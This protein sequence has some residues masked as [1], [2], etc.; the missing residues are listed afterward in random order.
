MDNKTLR[1]KAQDLRESLQLVSSVVPLNPTQVAHSGVH[2]LVTDGKLKLT[3]TDG[4]TT[5]TKILTTEGDVDVNIVV[6]PRP[7]L[8]LISKIDNSVYITL[9]IES[10][11]I[12]AVKVSGNKPYKFKTL[13]T[14][15]P[16]SSPPTDIVFSMTDINLSPIVKVLKN[17]TQKDEPV[18]SIVKTKDKIAFS[19]TDTYTL[20]YVEKK[21]NS[22]TEFDV[23][24]PYSVFEKASRINVDSIM[25]DTN[26]RIISFKS[27]DT[28]ITTRLNSNTYPPVGSIIENIPDYSVNITTEEPLQI[29]ARLASL[30]V[31]T[32]I[33]VRMHG[34][35]LEMS[36][37]SADIGS[38]S[39]E[40]KLPI[41]MKEEFVF[42]ARSNYLMNALT[43]GEVVELRYTGSLQPLHFIVGSK[44]KS[45]LVVMPVRV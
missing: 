5:I 34:D 22:Q 38:G 41:S 16:T 29:L 18:V 13:L 39:E 32:P 36:I 1:I 17:S 15:F 10:E 4:D 23:L 31:D 40:C 8:N 27:D 35:I 20:A 37:D 7:L 11:N 21:D 6:Q 14:T 33:K 30:S 25:M 2:M 24:V 28:Q 12:L 44:L 43:L 26:R 3:A 19:T 9:S 42:H 45:I